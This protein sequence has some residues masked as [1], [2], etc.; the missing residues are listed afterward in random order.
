MKQTNASNNKHHV[1]EDE[2][3]LVD[4]K[5]IKRCKARQ[6][7]AFGDLYRASLPYVL[8]IVRDY[9][10]CEETLKDIVQEVYSKAFLAIDSYSSRKGAFRFWLRKIAVN[11][12]LMHIRTNERRAKIL[13]D[14]VD[15]AQS[16]FA[17]HDSDIERINP[18]LIRKTISLMPDG[19]RNVFTLVVMNG[20]SHEEVGRELG[21]STQASRSQ[22]TRGKRWLRNYF[23]FN[24]TLADH[25]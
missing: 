2:R 9:I 11:E 8:K 3:V 12:C 23:K 15:I 24:K 17:N 5:V 21:I 20:Y 25:G 14:S 19:Y 10:Q 18:E 16:M 1:H 13:E 6:Q 7:D 22:L 4:Q